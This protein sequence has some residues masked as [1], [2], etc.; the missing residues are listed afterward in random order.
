MWGISKDYPTL[1]RNLQGFYFEACFLYR[2]D[3]L[4]AC[5]ARALYGKHFFG[6]VRIYFPMLYAFCTI[7]EGR[8]F[9]YTATAVDVGFEFHLKVEG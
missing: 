5:D 8:N 9:G 3:N 4:F 1:L 2:G 7:Q 6:N